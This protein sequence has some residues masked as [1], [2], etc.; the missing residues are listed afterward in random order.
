MDRNLGG[1]RQEKY[2]GVGPHIP[3]VGFA[4]YGIKLRTDATEITSLDEYSSLDTASKVTVTDKTWENDAD[5][6]AG[7][8]I[9]FEYLVTSIT[10]N[11]AGDSIW[12]YCVPF[13]SK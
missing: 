5:L 10:L 11:A 2:D 9:N 6:L 1:S 8:F 13:T 4:F 3:P 12:A 7:E